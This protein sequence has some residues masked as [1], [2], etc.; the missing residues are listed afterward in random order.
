[1]YSTEGVIRVVFLFLHDGVIPLG[2]PGK[3]LT[4][5]HPK[6]STNHFGEGLPRGSVINQGLM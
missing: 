5:Q 2:F 3:V 1:M 4:R 6:L